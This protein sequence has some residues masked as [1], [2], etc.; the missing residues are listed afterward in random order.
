MGLGSFPAIYQTCFIVEEQAIWMVGDRHLQQLIPK[1]LHNKQHYPEL[2]VFSRMEYSLDKDL[3]LQY[4][5]LPVLEMFQIHDHL[6]QVILLVAG[7][8]TVGKKVPRHKSGTD[9]KI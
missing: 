3:Q 4:V 1:F 9:V 5:Q 6:P 2:S 7:I 8:N